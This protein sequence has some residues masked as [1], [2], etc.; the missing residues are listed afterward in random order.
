MHANSTSP[1]LVGFESSTDSST[2]L[3]NVGF[4]EQDITYNQVNLFSH[5]RHTL[6]HELTI[7]TQARRIV[8]Q[9]LSRT[10]PN[11]K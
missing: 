6:L 3:P 2:F 5:P 8:L 4:Q 10:V 11:H 9:C 1:D 7:S